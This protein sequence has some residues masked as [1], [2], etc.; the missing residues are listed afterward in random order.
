MKRKNPILVQGKELW[1]IHFEALAT[2]RMP[3]TLKRSELTP[4]FTLATKRGWITPEEKNEFIESCVK[5]NIDKSWQKCR[6]FITGLNPK[7]EEDG[8]ALGGWLTLYNI[9]KYTNLLKS[10]RPPYNGLQERNLGLVT[11][12]LLKA[13]ELEKYEKIYEK[14][15]KRHLL[16]IIICQLCGT[17][18]NWKPKEDGSM[19]Y[20]WSTL[21]KELLGSEYYTQNINT[22]TSRMWVLTPSH[23]ISLNGKW[24]LPQLN[25]VDE[26]IKEL[27]NLPTIDK[28]SIL[29]EIK[30]DIC[31]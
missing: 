6:M 8:P 5:G 4:L 10:L 20:A 12:G 15:C 28:N 11:N 19:G 25:K 22:K 1:G 3:E 23:G 18:P 13:I 26:K 14:E 24:L 29:E 21:T 9:V 31:P 27:Y 17:D 30:M 7:E 16:G 2:G